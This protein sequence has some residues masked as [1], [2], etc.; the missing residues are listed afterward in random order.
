MRAATCRLL[1][2]LLLSATGAAAKDLSFTATGDGPRSE[3]DWMLLARQIEQDNTDGTTAF[4]LHL[5]DIW[6]GTERLPE[7]HYLQV[8]ALLRTSQAPVYIVPGDNEWTDLVNPA[9]GWEFW[10]RHLLRLD[11]HWQDK[12]DVS[13]QAGRKE[14]MAWLERGVLMI[15]VNMVG[16]EVKD[17]TAWHARHEAGAAWA[18]EQ[19]KAK[20]GRARA[21][22]I[23]AQA[24]PKAHHE[25][26]FAPVVEALRDYGKP[27]MYLHGD[28]HKYEVEPGWRLPNLTRVQ[29]DQVEKARPLLITVGD[30]PQPFS[31][32][33]RLP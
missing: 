24:K 26:F 16:G 33:R 14:N 10:T 29:V 12:P 19:L 17:L 5:G 30:G 18:V 2:A 20:G 7:S 22:V 4:L 15:G 23:F 6:K 3:A 1:L 13:R 8:A 27:A 31:F 28:G 32:D 21:V 9:E 25:D 11:A